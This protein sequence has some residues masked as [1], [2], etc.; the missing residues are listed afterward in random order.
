MQAPEACS[1]M[2]GLIF[3]L[4]VLQLLGEYA[5]GLAACREGLAEG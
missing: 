5:Q 3:L 4:S 1:D 2:D